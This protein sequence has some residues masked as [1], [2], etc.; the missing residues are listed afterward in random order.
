MKSSSKGATKTDDCDTLTKDSVN[1]YSE[2][3][4]AAEKRSSHSTSVG[5]KKGRPGKKRGARS[6]GRY[7]FLTKAKEYVEGRLLADTTRERE[8][9]NI[10]MLNR[11]VLELKEQGMIDETNPAKFTKK[12]VM[13]IEEAMRLSGRKGSTIEKY[14]GII[15]GVCTYHGN[16]IYEELKK[17][18]VQFSMRTSNEVRS[19]SSEELE[20]IQDA[21]IGIRRWTGEVCRFLVAILPYSGLRPTEL[22]LANLKDLNLDKMYIKVKNPKGKGKYGRERKAAILP[23]A[24]PAIVAYLKARKAYLEMNGYDESAEPLVPTARG[25]SGPHTYCSQS[26]RRCLGIIKSR[27]PGD[28]EQFS[29]KTFRATYLQIILKDHPELLEDVSY[30]MGH[31]STVTTQRYY[32]RIEEDKTVERIHN[33]FAR[34]LSEQAGAKNPLIDKK[35]EVTGYA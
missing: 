22:M 17:K 3:F 7:P 18:G 16:G 25:R 28:F 26:F 21:A 14:R 8:K 24:R 13:A 5:T 12:E 20:E 9:R 15:E 32:R 1:S 11:M 31:S 10:R 23:Q 2:G 4:D 6:V 34:P 29:L 27:L 33:A 35:F 30:S 19:L